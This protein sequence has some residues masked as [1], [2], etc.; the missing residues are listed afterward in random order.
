MCHKPD[1]FFQIA[2]R[3]CVKP[4]LQNQ[5]TANPAVDLQH[6]EG[7]QHIL[8]QAVNPL[9]SFF[10]RCRLISVCRERPRLVSDELPQRMF[11]NHTANH[12]RQQMMPMKIIK[13]SGCAPALR[14]SH[15]IAPTVNSQSDPQHGIAE[16]CVALWRRLLPIHSVS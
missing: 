9:G 1:G 10:L 4:R 2:P 7:F 14:V 13:T 11:T 5:S 12:Y 3:H 8:T 6:P 15:T 16:S